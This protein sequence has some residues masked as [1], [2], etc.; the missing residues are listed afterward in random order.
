MTPGTL[1]RECAVFTRALLGVAPSAYVVD[2]YVT[3]HRHREELTASTA[4]DL[5]LLRVARRG[6]W[7]C[8]LA[9]AF[10]ARFRRTGVLRAKLVVLVAILE[11]APP[12]YRTID[13][14]GRS[15]PV[16]ILELAG[17]G[18]AAIAATVVAVIVV[19]PVVLLASRQP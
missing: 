13:P 2:R 3:A 10:A 15:V 1:E 4:R 18:I 9:D 19:G 12:F 16:T 17:R 7:W 8:R 11:T 6:A 14:P 5:A